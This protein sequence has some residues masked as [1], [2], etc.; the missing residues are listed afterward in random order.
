MRNKHRRRYRSKRVHTSDAGAQLDICYEQLFATINR[1]GAKSD[2]ARSDLAINL[3]KSIARLCD[4][5]LAKQDTIGGRWAGETLARAYM[6]LRWH[7]RTINDANAAFRE[8]ETKLRKIRLDVLFPKSP[9][10]QILQEQLMTAERYQHRLKIIRAIY[11]ATWQHVARLAKIPRKYWP[12]VDLP[13][14][15]VASERGWW[16][17][18]WA[19]INSSQKKVLP[20]LRESAKGRAEAKSR[21]LYLKH[22]Y[23]QFSKHWR[24]LVRLREAGIF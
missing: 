5:A 23:K 19:L 24:T 6:H 15:C 4:I 11:P 10:G 7:R 20:R 8:T 16:E 12:A 17:F 9:V 13:R 14:F 21:P 1:R 3:R 18:I 22:F 2:Y